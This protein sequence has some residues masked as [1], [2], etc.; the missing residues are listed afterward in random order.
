VHTLCDPGESGDLQFTAQRTDD[1]WIF[2]PAAVP[3]TRSG[4]IRR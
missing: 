3:R 2:G 4:T 1:T